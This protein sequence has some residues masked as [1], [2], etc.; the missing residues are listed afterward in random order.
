VRVTS[1]V[2]IEACYP[3][4][5]G[6]PPTLANER[7]RAMHIYKDTIDLIMHIDII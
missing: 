4:M 3:G 7:D 2:T 5:L 1:G 6:L